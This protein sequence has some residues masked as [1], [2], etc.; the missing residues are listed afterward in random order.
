MSQ[1]SQRLSSAILV[2]AILISSYS[3]Y[4]VYRTDNLRKGEIEDLRLTKLICG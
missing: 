1:R 2:I 3:V 4:I